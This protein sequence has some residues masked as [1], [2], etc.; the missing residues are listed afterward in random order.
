MR[1]AGP[2]VVSD[3]SLGHARC[4]TNVYIADSANACIRVV[5]PAGVETTL[6][7]NPGITGSADGTGSAATF[8]NPPGLA[9]DSDGNVY[10]VD[11]G[12]CTIRKITPGGVVTTLAG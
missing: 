12:N 2:I 9:V 8:Y 5:T 3:K 7:G 6:A 11:N 4:A 1:S 10:V